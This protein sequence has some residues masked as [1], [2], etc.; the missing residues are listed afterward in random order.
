MEKLSKLL[1]TTWERSLFWLML[2]CMAAGTVAWL[3]SYGERS[4]DGLSGRQSPDHAS[5]LNHK[6][7]F[8]YREPSE[9]GRLPEN[10]LFAARLPAPLERPAGPP[11]PKFS[12]TDR[13]LVPGT[14]KG[15]DGGGDTPGEIGGDDGRIPT[16]GPGPG[17]EGKGGNG[18]PLTEDTASRPPTGGSRTD[19]NGLVG[20]TL[21]EIPRPGPAVDDD[22]NDPV[23]APAGDTPSS[24]PAAGPSILTIGYQGFVTMES[25]T[26][27]AYL[28]ETK[29][30]RSRFLAAGD[31]FAGGTVK[32]FDRDRLVFEAADGNEQ[33][34]EFLETRDFEVK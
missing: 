12:V 4:G 32:S 9:A 1:G 25:G 10:H 20:E 14:I 22:A 6:S 28:K 34:I 13:V 7:A 2:L 19:E 15:G 27:V 11:P 16:P 17:N 30:G 18:D 23:A 33:S 8:A 21:T 5:F 29:S 24:T 31:E 3:A 26:R